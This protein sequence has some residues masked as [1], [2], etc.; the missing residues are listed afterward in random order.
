MGLNVDE[1]IAEL[2][3][4][5]RRKVEAIACASN[6]RGHWSPPPPEQRFSSRCLLSQSVDQALGMRRRVKDLGRIGLLQDVE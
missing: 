5:E 3:P 2:D 4:A 1:I 6:S